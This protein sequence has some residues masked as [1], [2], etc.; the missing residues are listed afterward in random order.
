MSDRYKLCKLTKTDKP[1]FITL[2][3]K[4]FARDP[5]FQHAFG[6]PETDFKARDR[7]TAFLSFMFDKSLTLNEEIWGYFENESLKG[8]YAAE[9]PQAGRIRYWE[10]V[11]LIWRLIPLC[12]RLP[13]KTLIFLNDYMRVTRNAAPSLPHHYLIMIGVD[14]NAQGRGIG[15][16]LL[17]HLFCLAESDHRSQGI[18]LDTENE[19]NVVLYRRFGFTLN[20][21]TEIGSLPVYCLFYRKK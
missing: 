1:L 8:A 13:G 19:E 3:S 11:R 2:M 12:L 10:G 6:D 4:A 14:P 20:R 17:T 21:E 7:I 16:A 18:A 5:L 9:R 15:K